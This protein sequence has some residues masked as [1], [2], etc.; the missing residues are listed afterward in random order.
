MKRKLI[1]AASFILL[2]LSFTQCQKNCKVCQQ[3]TY[4][5][6]DGTLLTTGSETEYCDIALIGIENTKDVT[7]S[8]VT[9]KWVCR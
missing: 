5:E 1:Y 9:T 4:K 6:S 8:G 3:N 7:V 2:T